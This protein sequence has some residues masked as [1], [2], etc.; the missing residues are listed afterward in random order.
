MLWSCFLIYVRYIYA[1]TNI[2]FSLSIYVTIFCSYCNKRKAFFLLHDIFKLQNLVVIPT[3]KG[4]FFILYWTDELYVSYQSYS[5]VINNV[6]SQEK[7]VFQK[8][9]PINPVVKK[10]YLRNIQIRPSFTWYIRF[11]S[12]LYKNISF[13]NSI[14]VEKWIKKP[15]FNFFWSGLNIEK[16]KNSKYKILIETLLIYGPET[17]TIIQSWHS[18]DYSRKWKSIPILLVLVD[19]DME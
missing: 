15:Y 11:S 3:K 18:R 6:N 9:R 7:M 2:H 5:K 10:I 14:V 19:N 17:C 1:F 8:I 4:Y 16:G 12:Q 13:T